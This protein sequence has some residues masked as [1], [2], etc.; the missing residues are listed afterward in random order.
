M[1]PGEERRPSAPASLSAPSPHLHPRGQ[2]SGGSGSLPSR[3]SLLV[4]FPAGIGLKVRPGNQTHQAS[5][6][7][8][9]RGPLPS[10]PGRGS[11]PAPSPPAWPACL[12]HPG[13]RVPVGPTC[14]RR[15]PGKP[16]CGSW[17]A[18][19]PRRRPLRVTPGPSL[20]QAARSPKRDQDAPAAPTFQVPSPTMGILAPLQSTRWRAMTAALHRPRPGD[21]R[22]WL[23]A[24]TFK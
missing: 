6:E 16:E 24:R 21:Q 3:R 14:A 4:T 1:P 11:R 12:A 19:R 9:F 23:R 7:A 5:A 20:P 13:A 10:P 22:R 18:R 15:G 2:S 8:A 17:E